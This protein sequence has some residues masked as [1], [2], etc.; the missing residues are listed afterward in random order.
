MKLR[1]KFE[2]WCCDCRRAIPAGGGF[3]LGKHD[4]GRWYVACEGCYFGTT[5]EPPRSQ[6]PPP[7]FIPPCLEVLGL[8]PPVDRE[9][10]KRKFRQLAKATH[11][12]MGGDA[13]RFMAIEGAYREAM[14]L[15]GGVRP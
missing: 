11:P 4:S 9:T 3:L 2:A 7:V 6:P 14:A 13:G 1:N 8:M 15:A 10:V 5:G 12:D